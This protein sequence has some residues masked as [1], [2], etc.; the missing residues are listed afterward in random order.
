MESFG[1]LVRREREWRGLTTTLLAARI[2]ISQSTLS[3]IETDKF[4]ETPKP[5]VL[6]AL[7]RELG[8]SPER[9]LHALGYRLTTDDDTSDL[10]AGLARMVARWSVHQRTLLVRYVEAIQAAMDE[11]AKPDTAVRRNH[12]RPRRCAIH[13]LPNG[14][15][16]GKPGRSPKHA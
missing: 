12:G 13:R 10:A 9:L 8:L 14:D 3:R 15:G 11:T 6:H 7:S 2:G 4:A 16:I 5:R 1:F